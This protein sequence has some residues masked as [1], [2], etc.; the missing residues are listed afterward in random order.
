[1]THLSKK[2][3]ITLSS[4]KEKIKEARIKAVVSVN[5]ELLKVYWEIGNAILQQQ[6][7]EGWGA[8]IIDRLA[9][10]LKSEFPDFKGL[11]VRNLKYMRTFAEAYS[12][13]LIVQQDAAQLQ[14]SDKQENKFVQHAAAQIPWTH[15]QVILDKTKKLEERLFYIKKA[16]ENKWS[17]QVLSLQID[18]ELYNRQGNA[19]TNFSSTLPA[20]I[21]DLARETLKNPYI[22][23]F[24]SLGEDI[25][26]RE[27]EKALI[28]HLKNFLLELGRGF[29]YVGNQKN[30]NVKGDDFFLDLLFYNYHL[31][32]FVVIELKIGE[33]KPEFAGKLNFYINAINEQIKGPEDRPTIGVLLC[34]TPNETVIQYALTGIDNPIGVSDYELSQSLPKQLK[35]EIPSIEELEAEIEK[36]LKEL[37]SPSDKKLD[38]LKDILARLGKKEEPKKRTDNDVQQIFQEVI[39]LIKN[40]LEK[41]L[42]EIIQ[43]FDETEVTITVG[44]RGFTKERDAYDE[45]IKLGRSQDIR[46]EFRFNGFKRVETKAFF[47][48]L[49][50]TFRFETYN[51]QCS[52]QPF[53]QDIL[54]ERLYNQRPTEEELVATEEE[55][56]LRIIN[57]IEENLK[58]LKLL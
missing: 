52:F 1:M 9:A 20:P 35:G 56:A 4:L 49:D 40:R 46:M 33:F 10:D 32:C 27:L 25:Q 51:Y 47:C 36:E 23:D 54:W 2:Y 43:L 7:E 24:L 5:Y 19:I 17:R 39:I 53:S 28:Q 8:K 38:H 18:S 37:K 44:N 6:K 58:R 31:H 34:K 50:I 57:Q 16:V 15:H 12:D 22:F 30:L 13:F 55:Y 41:K 29:A 42:Q 11:S 3:Q 48:A 45:L 14:T 26:E 21:S